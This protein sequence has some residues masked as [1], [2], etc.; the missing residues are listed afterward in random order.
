[1]SRSK[2]KIATTTPARINSHMRKFP[3]W[4]ISTTDNLNEN[5][6][7]EEAGRLEISVVLRKSIGLCGWAALRAH[8]RNDSY[9]KTERLARC[10]CSKFNLARV[11]AGISRT[12]PP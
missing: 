1:M 10:P 6:P 2:T 3:R 8:D 11:R 4:K 12:V 5:R 7:I 9:Q